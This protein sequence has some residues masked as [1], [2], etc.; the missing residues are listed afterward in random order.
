VKSSNV[1]VRNL[2]I[3]GVA[4]TLSMAAESCSSGPTMKRVAVIVPAGTDIVFGAGG[5]QGVDLRISYRIYDPSVSRATRSKPPWASESF[6][7]DNSTRAQITVRAHRDTTMCAIWA[8]GQRNPLVQGYSSLV[9]TC[10]VDI[11]VRR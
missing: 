5:R 8:S 11:K 6:K 9:T 2:I 4:L 1:K 3:A 10:A 7:I